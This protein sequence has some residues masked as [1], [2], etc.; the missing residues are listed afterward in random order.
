[1]KLSRN[2]KYFEIKKNLVVILPDNYAP[3]P[4]ECEVCNFLL[5][6]N[7]DVMSYVI[8]SCCNECFHTWV[9][10]D[11]KAWLDG[12]RPKKSDIMNERNK[13]IDRPL[14]IYK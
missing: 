4:F 11:P 2:R 14:Y 10:V 1:M 7:A 8:Y 3:I 9:N 12:K 5:R 6:D 13:R